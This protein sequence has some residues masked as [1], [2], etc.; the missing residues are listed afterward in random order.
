M[1]LGFPYSDLCTC[2]KLL[3]LGLITNSTSIWSAY[4]LLHLGRQ[5]LVQS[6]EL[7]HLG[8]LRWPA[9]SEAL[10]GAWLGDLVGGMAISSPGPST[11]K[12]GALPCARGR[13]QSP[14]GRPCRCSAGCCTRRHPWRWRVSWL[15]A[16][17]RLACCQRPEPLRRT[18]SFVGRIYQELS[19]VLVRDIR[20]LLAV[21]LGDNELLMGPNADG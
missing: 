15:Q 2:W 20:Q 3:K 14:G 6:L 18:G 12:H 17:E 21:V 13:A 8:R 5:L 19:Q 1:D 7:V 4:A 10:L 11:A 9:N 16:I